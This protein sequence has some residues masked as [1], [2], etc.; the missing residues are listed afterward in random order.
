[1][2]AVSLDSRCT[3]RLV[4]SPTKLPASVPAESSRA[5][6][7][8]PRES[9]GAGGRSRSSSPRNRPAPRQRAEPRESSSESATRGRSAETDARRGDMG[10]NVTAPAVEGKGGAGLEHGAALF[11]YIPPLV[12]ETPTVITQEPTWPSRS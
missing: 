9:S 4:P 5:S 2:N 8:R 7:A 6:L 10:G 12:P 11:L 1:M 3:A